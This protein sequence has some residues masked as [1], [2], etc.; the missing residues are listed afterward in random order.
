MRAVV[1]NIGTITPP[2]SDVS[3][4]LQ[5]ET[6][7][8]LLITKNGYKLSNSYPVPELQ[9]GEVMIR[10][11]A[12]GL[13]PIDW[14]SVEYNFCLPEHPWIT[15]REMA[16]VVARLGPGVKSVSVGDRVWTSK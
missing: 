16:G 1:L 7:N 15:G 4:L 9:T 2:A 6:Q 10:N 11:H 13:N 5:P 12:T 14:K 8:A 3:E